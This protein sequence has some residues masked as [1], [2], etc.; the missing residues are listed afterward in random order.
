MARLSDQQLASLFRARVGLREQALWHLLRDTGIAA[1]A[2]LRM[3]ASAIER[4]GRPAARASAA[5][6]GPT[7]WTAQTSDLL[8]WLLSGRSLGPVFLTDR[9]AAAWT[10]RADLCPLTGRARMSYR[11]AA[12]IFTAA[13]RVLDPS[14]QGWMLH[15]LR[16]GRRQPRR[17]VRLIA[18]ISAWN[19]RT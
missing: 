6:T 5:A 18:I 7:T 3:D 17:N 4:T 2:A 15:Q 10:P 8:S 16:P 12:E 9:R 13:T 11:R 14:G 1:P 19:L